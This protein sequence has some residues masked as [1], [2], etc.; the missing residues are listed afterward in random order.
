ML[1]PLMSR[2]CKLWLDVNPVFGVGRIFIILH[3]RPEDL[4][5]AKA[6]QGRQ[7]ERTKHKGN[8]EFRTRNIE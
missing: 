8:I 5:F 3:P 4:Y 2:I 1:L 6:S 7:G